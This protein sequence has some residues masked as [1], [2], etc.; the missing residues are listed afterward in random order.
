[1]NKIR[2]TDIDS[3]RGFLVISV[4]IFHLDQTLFPK[5][6]LAVDLFFVISG[7]LITKSVIKSYYKNNFNFFEYYIKRIRRILPVLLIVLLTS[8]LVAII[9]LLTSDLKKFSE[10]LISSLGFVSN[11]YFWIT[12][13]YFSTSDQLKPLLHTWSLSVEEQFYLF[14][15]FFIY[16]IFKISKKLN[17]YLCAIILISIISFSVNIFLISKGHRDAIFFLFPARIWQFGLGVFFAFLPNIII[18]NLWIDLLY[19]L[20]AIFLI[21]FNFV[22]IVDYLPNATLMCLGVALILYKK[23]NKRNFLSN[24][25]KFKPL[26]FI[27]LISYNLYLWHWPI[28]S[29]F[30]YVYMGQLTLSIMIISVII[31]TT[32][33]ILS[34][35]FVEQP[36]LYKHSIKKVL[37][38]VAIGY[39]I[40]T[41]LSITIIL[42]KDL[43][44]RYEK[45]PNLL[46]NSIGST[47]TCSIKE[48]IKFGDTYAC[49][50]NP[51]SQLKNKNII[52]GNSHAF[53]Y[54]WALKNHWLNKKQGGLIIQMNTCLPFID[55]NI[56][57][58]CLNKA[59]AYYNSIIQSD[60]LKNII[61]GFHWQEN[62]L[63][64]VH[65]DIFSDKKFNYTKKSIDN[66]ITQL[67]NNNK[68]VFLIGPIDIPNKDFSSQ[69]SREIIFKNKKNYKLF[70]SRN[71]FDKKYNYILEYYVK[72]L[73]KNFLQP[74][75][76]LCN[77]INCYFADDNGSYFSDSNH[78][79]YHGA[80]KTSTIFKIID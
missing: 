36:F 21:L 80:M 44:S 75:R 22:Y 33:S 29:I 31:T 26:I 79:S 71:E 58:K 15:P 32:L 23:D 35:R 45:F 12:G 55:K 59:K 76:L 41:T 20:I 49:L 56:S 67:K 78:L 57:I 13:G 4:I 69:L 65:G 18:K 60:D 6:Y 42:S 43:P 38:F 16:I 1:M 50:I 14:F 34:W 53:M 9:I 46:A 24:I 25:F 63:V 47:Y 30:K 5:G 68:N 37:L 2:R 64:D 51:K 8:L 70:K 3:I 52:F 61:I 7:Y 62:K 66:L 40:L 10:S 73:D 54:G 28:I 74:H 11:F 17:F 77:K 72:K 27:G 48:Y 39:F 19:L